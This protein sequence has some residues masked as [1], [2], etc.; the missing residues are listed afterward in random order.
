V[1]NLGLLILFFMLWLT[2]AWLSRGMFDNPRRDAKWGFVHAFLNLYARCWHRLRVQGRSNIPSSFTPG[3]LIVIANHTAGVDPFLIQSVCPFEIRWMMA[4]DMMEPA[5]DEIWNWADVIPVDRSGK[6]TSS[7]RKAIA[8]LRARQVLGV[9]P[10]G[11]LE[12]PAQHILP[13]LP[14]LGIMIKRT[15]ARILPVIIDG[16]P[17]VDPAWASVCRSSRSTLR[18]LP[19]IDYSQGELGPGEIVED[20]RKRFAD[21]TGWPLVEAPDLDAAMRE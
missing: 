6:D 3:P 16:T 18:V 13:F 9:F 8:H 20:L 19:M 2:W 15:G 7:A 5:L 4:L 12:R 1:T 14:G 17:Q 21:W 11:R 10:E